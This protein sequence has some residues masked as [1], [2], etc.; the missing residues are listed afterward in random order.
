MRS[1]WKIEVYFVTVIIYFVKNWEMVQIGPEG[2]RGPIFRFLLLLFSAENK[3]KLLYHTQSTVHLPCRV[4]KAKYM[5]F[6]SYKIT[7]NCRSSSRFLIFYDVRIEPW[8][9][10][11]A[12][13]KV[14]HVK[15]DCYSS[16]ALICSKVE[17]LTRTWALTLM[18]RSYAQ[19]LLNSLLCYNLLQ[20]LPALASIAHH[21]QVKKEWEIEQENNGDRI[22]RDCSIKH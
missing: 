20:E 10:V 2:L 18:P 16:W 5:E 1:I 12:L 7:R 15:R 11:I 14:G 9:F 22:T 17:L 6:T 3:W 19:G 4:T 21:T 8:K 13:Y